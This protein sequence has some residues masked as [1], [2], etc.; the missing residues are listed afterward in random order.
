MLQRD[1]FCKIEK[2]FFDKVAFNEN[3][4][5]LTNLKM[6]FFWLISKDR[7]SENVLNLEIT[8]VVLVHCNSVRNDYQQD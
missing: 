3:N 5:E 2:C 8:E 1:T 6:L 4:S 7:N